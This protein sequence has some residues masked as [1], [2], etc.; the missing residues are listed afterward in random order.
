MRT[1][2]GDQT[3]R[4]FPEA[5]QARGLPRL[6]VAAAALI[7]LLSLA[8]AAAVGLR[9]PVALALVAGGGFGAGL[10]FVLGPA[11]RWPAALLVGGSIVLTGIV[12]IR[13]ASWIDAAL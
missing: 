10:L 12:L 11:P 8:L 6:A 2:A 3:I 5:H 7:P 4:A 9:G 13:A 1:G